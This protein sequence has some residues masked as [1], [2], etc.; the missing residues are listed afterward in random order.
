MN[1]RELLH[2]KM[3]KKNFS[4]YRLLEEVGSS[5]KTLRQYLNGKTISGPYL[6]KILEVLEI[7]V[8]EWNNCDN[9]K[10]VYDEGMK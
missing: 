8:E 7:S 6:T 4:K 10:S 2:N 1:T 5:E 9:I 3:Q